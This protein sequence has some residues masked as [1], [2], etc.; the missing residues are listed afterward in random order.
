MDVLLSIFVGQITFVAKL[1]QLI[2]NF[3]NIEYKAIFSSSTK[4]YTVHPHLREPYLLNFFKR[5]KAR[6]FFSSI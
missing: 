1:C 4:L 5:V 6:P 2:A 3:P